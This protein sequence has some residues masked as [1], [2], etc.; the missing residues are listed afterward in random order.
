M[1][2][3]EEFP[4][5]FF[6]SKN[7]RRYVVL[8]KI[9]TRSGV[10]NMYALSFLFRST[11][12]SH[13]CL[14]DSHT[15]YKVIALFLSSL[16][17]STHTHRI[18]KLPLVIPH[19]QVSQISPHSQASK[20][21]SHSLTFRML[22]HSPSFSPHSPATCHTRSP[23]SLVYYHTFSLLTY[24]SFGGVTCSHDHFISSTLVP[25]ISQIL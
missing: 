23:H 1:N 24:I 8:Q 14:F 6:F 7:F 20:V 10:C 11:S 3:V 22:P 17:L 4:I 21:S 9:N 13:A 18:S 5:F 2:Y 19:L 12:M 16:S 25:L 15:C